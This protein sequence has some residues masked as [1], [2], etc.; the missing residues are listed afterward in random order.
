VGT[1]FQAILDWAYARRYQGTFVMRI[2]DT[3][4]K[5]FVSEAETVLHQA[6]AWLNITPDEGPTIGGNYGPYRQSQRLEIYQKY[7]QQLVDQGHAYHCFCSPER[8]TQLREEQRL[9]KQPP[10]YDQHCRHLSVEEVEQKLSSGEK[11]VIRLKVPE[12]RIILVNDVLRG[13]IKF[14]ARVVDDQVLLKS[15]GFPT[16]HLAVV[17]DDHLM[18]ITH[19][20]RGEEWLPSAPKHILLY[21]YF[22]W[23]VPLLIHTPTLRSTDRSKLSKRKG[24]TSVW[25]YRE[26]GF[27]PEAMANFLALLVWKPS[28]NQEIFSM[29]QMI[30]QFEWEEMNITGPIFDLKKLEWLN[31][32]YMRQ[33]SLD[34]LLERLSAWFAWVIEAGEDNVCIQAV[35]EL[36]QWQKMNQSLFSKAIELS[37]E[38]ART[39]L[40][41]HQLLVLYFTDDLQYDLED[42]TQG[43]P[44]ET[45]AQALQQVAVKLKETKVVDEKVWENTIRLM[46]DEFALSH[47]ELFMAMRSAL[48]A[49]RF[50]PPLFDVIHA[51]GEQVS[52]QRLLKAVSF[53]KNE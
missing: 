20:V 26:H 46:A 23:E 7:A 1:A 51:L 49:Q 5:R 30:E 8:L 47:K 16:Y 34:Q 53:L 2:E 21:E 13:T 36:Q 18:K 9:Q 28:A 52:Y 33:L 19:I 24:N 43:K 6:F 40:E 42:L 39:L 48:T 32:K 27:L 15:D 25:W 11:S 3:D 45:V 22:G 37:Q 10:K 4:Q 44:R 29:Q 50:T 35:Q 38:R 17:I 31:G 12:D 41:F 14:D